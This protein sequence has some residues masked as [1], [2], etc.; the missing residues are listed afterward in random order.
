MREN[1]NKC[2]PNI[3]NKKPKLI[4]FC[5]KSIIIYYSLRILTSII[6]NKKF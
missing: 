1:C 5:E 3:E 4:I 2:L 6:Y